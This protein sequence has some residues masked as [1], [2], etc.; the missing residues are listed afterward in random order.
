MVLF[1]GC[2]MKIKS[3]LIGAA[4]AGSMLAAGAAH[5]GIVY[6]GPTPDLPTDSSYTVTFNLGSALNSSLSWQLCT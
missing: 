4:L 3:A 2:S 1:E 6:A 5:A